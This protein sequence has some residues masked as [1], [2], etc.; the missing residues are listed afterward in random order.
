MF[1]QKKIVGSRKFFCNFAD[2]IATEKK[3]KHKKQ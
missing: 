3:Y 2:E 1:Y